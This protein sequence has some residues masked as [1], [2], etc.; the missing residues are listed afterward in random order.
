[1]TIN[2]NEQARK[3]ALL[4]RLSF[5]T[6]GIPSTPN[7]SKKEKQLPFPIF[8]SLHYLVISGLALTSHF[9]MNK[10]L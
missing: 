5:V 1:M 10:K 3:L 6:C 2:K 4:Y 8:L 7:L 9:F